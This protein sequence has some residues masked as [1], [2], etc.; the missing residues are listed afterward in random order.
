[1]LG[2]MWF[3]DELTLGVSNDPEETEG[4]LEDWRKTAELMYYANSVVLSSLI[5]VFKRKYG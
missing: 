1:M 4:E 5:N 3:Y 2:E